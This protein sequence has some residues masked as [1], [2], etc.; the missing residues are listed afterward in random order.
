MRL[1]AGA[2]VGQDHAFFDFHK[3]YSGQLDTV[4]DARRSNSREDRW[5]LT[6]PGFGV[7]KPGQYGNGSLYCKGSDLEPRPFIDPGEGI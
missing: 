7:H 5:V 6:A 2:I 4:F 1:K 3:Y